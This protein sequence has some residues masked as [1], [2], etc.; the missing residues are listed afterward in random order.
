V[1]N[2]L[3]AKVEALEAQ[4]GDQHP[5][6]EEAR[7]EYKKCYDELLKPR[8]VQRLLRLQADW[9]WLYCQINREWKYIKGL[10]NRER[11]W[12][13]LEFVV[14]RVERP[15]EDVHVVVEEHT[16]SFPFRFESR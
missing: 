3:H 11:I 14:R 2:A 7:S 12:K 10:Q 1:E 13:T 8:P 15:E 16:T 6:I 9:Y 5:A 4:E